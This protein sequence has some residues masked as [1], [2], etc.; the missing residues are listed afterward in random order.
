MKPERNRI[1]N[2]RKSLSHAIRGLFYVLKNERNFQIELAVAMGVLILV[3]YFKIKNWE[4]IILMLM[5]MWVLISELINTVMERIVDILKPKIHPYAR[6][7][8]D[9]MAAVVLISSIVAVIVGVIIFLP[10]IKELW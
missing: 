9:I 5:I 1:R 2:F 4:A 8:K 7:V 3:W 10:Y 6:L